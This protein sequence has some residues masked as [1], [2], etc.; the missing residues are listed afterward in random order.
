[1]EEEK[2][3]I[4]VNPNELITEELGGKVMGW[5]TSLRL[6]YSKPPPGAAVM[7]IHGRPGVLLPNPDVLVICFGDYFFTSS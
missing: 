1:M 2:G 3:A 4:Y 6:E 5:N 7:M